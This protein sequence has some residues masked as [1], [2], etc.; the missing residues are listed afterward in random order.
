MTTTA[1]I[2]QTRPYAGREVG[3]LAWVGVQVGVILLLARAFHLESPAFYN[4]VLPLAAGGFLVH[5]WLPRRYQLWFFVALSVA[6]M[7]L[8][9]GLVSGAWLVGIGLGLIALCHVPVAFRWRIVLILVAAGVL[10]A[11]RTRWLPAPWPGAIWPVLGSLFMFRLGIYLHDLKHRGP[12]SPGFVLSYF[13]LL[14]NSV[15]LLFPVIDFQTFRRTH[16]DKPAFDIY[17]EGV[18]WMFRGLTHLVIY[19][20][21]Y[22][23]VALSPADVT[24]TATLVQYLVGNFGLLLRVSGQFHMIVGLLHL[25]GFRLPET[26]R[27]YFL[28]SSLS[29][30]WRRTNIYW[31]EFMQKMV[32]LPVILRL[33]QRGDTA[34][35]VGA[36]TCVVG[37]T[38]F[39]HSYQW[40][41]LLGEWLLSATD[42]AYW[43]IIG[44]LLIANT[45]REQRQ[46]RARLVAAQ[47]VTALHA[48]R[49][50]VQTAGMF[51]LMAFLWGLWTS[52][53]FGDFRVM[54]GAAT[55]RPVDVAV[56]LGTLAV[57]AAAAYLTRLFGW[58]TPSA[59][60]VPPRWQH[61]LVVAAAPLA[62]LWIVGH[63]GL[64]GRVPSQVQAIVQQARVA[65]LNKSDAE[66]LQRGYYERIVGVNRFN[67]E[68]W[69][70]YAR[71][72]EQQEA[73]DILFGDVPEQGSGD[74]SIWRRHDDALAY[75]LIP[76][77]RT[78]FK[79]GQFTTNRWGMRDKDYEKT[80]PPRTRRIA[81]LG[82]SYTMGAGVNDGE[83]F[84]TLIE[85]RLNREWSPKTGFRYEVLNFAVS[86]YL[87]DKHA[88][89]MQNGRVAD[90]HP[91]VVLIVGSPGDENN[92]G[93][94]L[95]R[96]LKLGL[97]SEP[98][99]TWLTEA[100]VTRETSDFEAV[101]RL[102]RRSPDLVRL[103]L[104]TI[105]SEARRMG[106][107]PVFALIPVPRMPADQVMLL[108][109]V[110]DAGLLAVDLRDV[111]VGH[112]PRTLTISE[113]DFHPNKEGHQIIAERLYS[114]LVN[115]PLALLAAEESMTAEDQARLWEEWNRRQ[116]AG[117]EAVEARVRT[118]PGVVA[119]RTG[120]AADSTG[121]RADRTRPGPTGDRRG[122]TGGSGIPA[123]PPPIEGWAVET[124]DGNVAS[125]VSR[126][127]D[128]WMRVTIQKLANRSPS[129]IR[130]Q[131]GPVAVTRAHRYVLTFWM[132][133]DAARPVTCGLASGTS[134]D[135]LL[136]AF[137]NVN[138]GTWWQESS[139]A[140]SATAT[141]ANA[142]IF[143]DLGASE[144]ALEMSRVELR[145][146]STGTVVMSTDPAW[147][148]PVPRVR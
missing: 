21:I 58:G 123:P 70:V 110:A 61:P 34:A 99:T 127:A 96:Q 12:S 142:R 116:L 69:E 27:F 135:K 36:T 81:L 19:R 97:L 28:A 133:G 73:D 9:F 22:Q 33:R 24:S 60:T 32:F 80:P 46:G 93:K 124:R 83:T 17:A 26:H 50:A 108:P 31:K 79:G 45:L 5:H 146:V 1:G 128:N 39:L 2:E 18:R 23:Y 119:S 55:W 140:F 114:E 137:T 85:E 139:C 113:K 102:K 42:I 118:Q 143:F 10:M 53:T 35:L 144:V 126:R 4:I 64:E 63:P 134:P 7:L 129:S 15:F 103:A 106:A 30:F 66:R 41:W 120:R 54:L 14:P 95:V 89:I 77:N 94:D 122:P 130:L 16:Y 136:G 117:Q 141:D 13:F 107:Q 87:L 75:D 67:G 105:V 62:L 88:L 56:V 131:S 138:A 101:T 125:L 57:V 112:D 104:D 91:D 90:F 49:P 65:E 115:M 11:M 25:F 86:G 100:G 92:I 48:W 147:K 76:L 8:V 132:N 37:A 38:W 82:P 40:F 98:V 74:F 43:A 44:L 84:E 72:N 6:G 78:T 3:A 145:D 47:A 59:L 68:L 111:Y 20:L 29:D 121:G 71:A 51:A 52:P 109:A 148:P